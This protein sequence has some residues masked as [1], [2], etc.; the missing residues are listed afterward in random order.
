MK[1]LYKGYKEDVPPKQP[2]ELYREYQE[3]Y[4]KKER[5]ND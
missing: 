5:K 4:N 2:E 3:R 1:N